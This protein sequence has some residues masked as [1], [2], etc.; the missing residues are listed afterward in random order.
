M[1]ISDIFGLLL[2]GLGGGLKLDYRYNLRGFY[3]FPVGDAS[4]R[5]RETFKQVYKSFFLCRG[6]IGFQT[7][8]NLRFLNRLLYKLSSFS[9]VLF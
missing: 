3:S 5:E 2:T 7:L 1:E 8:I 4:S 6:F 9:C